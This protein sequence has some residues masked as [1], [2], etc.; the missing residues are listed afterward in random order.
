MADLKVGECLAGLFF[1]QGLAGLEED[2]VLLGRLLDGTVASA[3]HF[4]LIWSMEYGATVPQSTYEVSK[5][6]L[7]KVDRPCCSYN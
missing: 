2:G 7:Y 5:S 4:Y 6:L 3:H 1:D